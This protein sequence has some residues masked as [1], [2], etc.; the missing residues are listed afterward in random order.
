MVALN[1]KCDSSRWDI[2]FEMWYRDVFLQVCISCATFLEDQY[3]NH[4]IIFTLIKNY[5]SD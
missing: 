4:N 5:C 3:Q 1:L 2:V